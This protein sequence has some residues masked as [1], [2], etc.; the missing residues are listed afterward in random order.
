MDDNIDDNMDNNMDNNMDDASTEIDEEETKILTLK[1]WRRS[2]KK[3]DNV[4]SQ[5]TK[6]QMD[7]T[8]LVNFFVRDGRQP[9]NIIRA[10]S[11]DTS[12]SSL[13]TSASVS[14]ASPV[15]LNLPPSQTQKYIDECAEE[16]LKFRHTFNDKRFDK[17]VQDKPSFNVHI[18]S[19]FKRF[20]ILR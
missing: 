3:L 5:L 18:K 6:L 16:T 4:C 15:P 10:G 8:S 17:D 2:E 19:R 13:R 9:P 11:I 20:A 14:C 7:V 12:I 1:E